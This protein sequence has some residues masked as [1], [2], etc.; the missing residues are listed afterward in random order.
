MR[1]INDRQSQEIAKS[2][3]S[4]KM[5]DYADKTTGDFFADVIRPL[6]ELMG[7]E[8]L[9]PSEEAKLKKENE[10]LKAELE[11]LKPEKKPEDLKSKK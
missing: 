9:Q 3:A 11:E 5:S 7:I 10:K 2:I 8:P 6:I 1:N 4:R